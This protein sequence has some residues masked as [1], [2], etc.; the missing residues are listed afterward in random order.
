MVTEIKP[1][2]YTCLNPI[3]PANLADSAGLTCQGSDLDPKI[4]LTVYTQ[5]SIIIKQTIGDKQTRSKE[6]PIRTVHQSYK[7][8]RK[9][10]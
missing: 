9:S 5:S 1:K 8:N 6:S 7:N 3:A 4:H 10:L 2:C